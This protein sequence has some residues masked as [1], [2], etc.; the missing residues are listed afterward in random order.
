MCTEFMLPQSTNF[1]VSGR[2]MD[3]GATPK[4]QVAAVPAGTKMDAIHIAFDKPALKWKAEYG[5]VG[6]GVKL[7]GNLFSNKVCDAMNTEGLSAAALWLPP[8]V[9]PKKSGG[10]KDAK[11]LSAMDICG[12]AAARFATVAELRADLEAIRD[13]L[14]ISTGETVQFWDPLQ[15]GFEIAHQFGKDV[16]NFL[17]LH[18]QFHDRSGASLV[19]EFRN[20]KPEIT[21]NCDLGVMTNAPFLDWHRANLQNF[22]GVSNVETTKAKIVGLEVERAGNGGGLV[23]L[24]A[25]PLPADRFVRTALTLDFSLPWFRQK[26]GNSEVLA[27]AFNVL[28]G[29]TVVHGQCVDRAG[30][31]AGDFTQWR[32]VRDHDNNVLY[33]ATSGSLGPWTIPFSAFDL[34]CGAQPQYVLLSDAEA[35][36]VLKAGA[37]PAAAE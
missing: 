35:M 3:F 9:Y 13:G 19:L 15:F 29:V 37:E 21:D 14:P 31:S 7:K 6:V 32:L 28:A 17:P 22:L 10:P 27:H 25:S 30:S 11:L 1:R 36:P 33:L 16:Q 26:R 20:G 8:S 18:F 23:G 5:F 12:W 34:G 2:T 4:W 24:S